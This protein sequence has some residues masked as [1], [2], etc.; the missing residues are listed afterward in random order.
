MTFVRLQFSSK[1]VV[2]S[3][4]NADVSAYFDLRWEGGGGGSVEVILVW[5]SGQEF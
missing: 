3:N 2:Y 4:Q 5:M 1:V